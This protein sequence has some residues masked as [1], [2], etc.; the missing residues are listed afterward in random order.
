MDKSSQNGVINVGFF[1]YTGGINPYIDILRDGIEKYENIKVTEFKIDIKYNIMQKRYDVVYINWYENIQSNTML[2]TILSAIKR[3]FILEILRRRNTRIILFAHNRMP[4]NVKNYTIVRAFTKCIYKIADTI[5]VLSKGTKTVL[6]KDFGEKYFCVIKDKFV[7]IPE[8][9]YE[10]YYPKCDYNYRAKWNIAI[11]DF[12]YLTPGSIL[13]YKNYDLI[14]KTAKMITKKYSKA[15]FIIY[16]QCEKTYYDKLMKL[17]GNNNNI[18]IIPETIPVENMVALIQCANVILLPLDLNSSLNSGTCF[19]AL[20]FG[21]NIVCPR[22]ESLK[23][24]EED[25]FFDYEYSNVEE[26]FNNL[27]DAEL[28]A[29]ELFYHNKREFCNRISKIQMEIHRR[30]SQEIVAEKLVNLIID[31]Y[32]GDLS[33][34]NKI[35]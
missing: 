18:V 15:K 33:N 34:D 20:C 31:T 27:Y 5:A 17:C 14:I 2:K 13:K 1:P 28:R 11:D 21:R 24:F 12:I 26:H 22:I 19:M 29:I 23:D 9:T 3:I 30:F 6:E 8:P 35:E 10:G 7:W 25:Y 32:K 16:G 4:H